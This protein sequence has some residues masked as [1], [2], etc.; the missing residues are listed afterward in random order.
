MIG[1]VC[2]DSI[3]LRRKQPEVVEVGFC[4]VSRRSS[5]EVEPLMLHVIVVLDNALLCDNVSGLTWPTA[6]RQNEQYSCR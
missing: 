1:N 2:Y 4:Y 5:L 6:S 3:E